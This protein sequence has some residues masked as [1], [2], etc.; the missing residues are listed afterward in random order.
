[1]KSLQVGDLEQLHYIILARGKGQCDVICRYVGFNGVKF[2]HGFIGVLYESKSANTDP[3]LSGLKRDASVLYN[4]FG[5]ASLLLILVSDGTF[6][7]SGMEII[8]WT[9]FNAYYPLHRR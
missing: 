3:V 4:S 1:M 5:A 6:S 8:S 7:S 9:R 2:F